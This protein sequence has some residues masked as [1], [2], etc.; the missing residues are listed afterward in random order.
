MPEYR[1][2]TG[3]PKRSG[4]ARVL[5]DCVIQVK[6]SDDPETWQPIDNGHQTLMLP[7]AAVLAITTGGGTAAQ[8][9]AAL[10]DLFQQEAKSWGIDESDAAAT[11]IEVL[12]TSWPVEV[13][14]DL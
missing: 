14:L 9:R 1:A 12:V 6:V 3:A 10:R 2:V 13:P 7:A 11:D 4:D 5:F 8:K